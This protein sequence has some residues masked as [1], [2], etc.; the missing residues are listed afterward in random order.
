[1]DGKFPNVEMEQVEG[2]DTLDPL[3][4]FRSFVQG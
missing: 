2:I 3:K 4:L 1:M